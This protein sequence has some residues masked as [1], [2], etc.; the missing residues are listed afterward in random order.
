MKNKILTKNRKHDAA[1]TTNWDYVD[2]NYGSVRQRKRSM[3]FA[4]INHI[5][6]MH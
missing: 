4:I 6:R 1:V 5:A 2:W 3:K